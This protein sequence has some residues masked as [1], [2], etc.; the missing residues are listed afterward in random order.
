MTG[1]RLKR[2][3]QYL[4]ASEPFCMTYGDGVS[5]V[6][7]RALVRFAREQGTLAT[8]TATRPPARFGAL[9][10]EDTKVR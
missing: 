3:G 8:V 1:G 6:D 5:N 9:D 4:E 10:L 7:I 2:I